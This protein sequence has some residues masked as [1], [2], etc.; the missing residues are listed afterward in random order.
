MS[1]SESH[2]RAAKSNLIGLAHRC[3][4]LDS[5]ALEA[6]P[7][8]SKSY[9]SLYKDWIKQHEDKIGSKGCLIAYGCEFSDVYSLVSRIL[10][11]ISN[12]K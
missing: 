5:E 8:E 10:N 4:E 6:F 12:N 2:I 9:L 1:I 11:Q 7:E 3:Q